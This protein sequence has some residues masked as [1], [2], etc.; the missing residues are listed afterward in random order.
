MSTWAVASKLG[1]FLIQ[2][3]T[4]R[5][6]GAGRVRRGEVVLATA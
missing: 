4:M 2:F 5:L 3:V 1:L 6:I